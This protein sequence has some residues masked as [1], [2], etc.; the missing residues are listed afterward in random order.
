MKKRSYLKGVFWTITC[1]RCK[2]ELFPVLPTILTRYLVDDRELLMASGLFRP[3]IQIQQT[4][5]RFYARCEKCK[6]DLLADFTLDEIK[7]FFEAVEKFTKENGFDPDDQ[8]N[9]DTDDALN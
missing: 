4:F 9:G 5:L 1:P 3:Q 2:E 6:T 7:G 8:Q